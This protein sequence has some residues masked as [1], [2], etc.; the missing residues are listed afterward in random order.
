MGGGGGRVLGGLTVFFLIDPFVVLSAIQ[1]DICNRLVL[2]QF[3]FN[4]FYFEVVVPTIPLTPYW[5][6]FL[7]CVS[8]IYRLGFVISK[9]C[10]L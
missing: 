2:G 5:T 3:L 9:R 10:S 1:L 7:G 8:V 4:S 6:D